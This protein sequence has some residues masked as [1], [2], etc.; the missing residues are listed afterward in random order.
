MKRN[1]L[2]FAGTIVLIPA[3][4]FSCERRSSTLVNPSGASEDPPV[5]VEAVGLEALYESL[6]AVLYRYVEPCS[7]KVNY[8]GFWAD[9][10][11][12]SICGRIARFDMG[13]LEIRTDSLAFL[14]NAYNA[15]FIRQLRAY[16]P[17][18]SVTPGDMVPWERMFDDT[19]TV[20]GHR[21]TL[22]QLEK[23]DSS[24]IKRFNEPRTHFVL[25]C[26]AKSC[27]PLLGKAYRGGTLY[28]AL[29]YQT[30]RFI[31]NGRFNPL[32]SSP[33]TVSQ[34][35]SWYA[36]EFSGMVRD[37]NPD[38]D[39]KL[40]TLENATVKDFIGSYLSDPLKLSRLASEGLSFK[41]YNWEINQL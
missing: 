39:R 7:G 33:P 18:D 16:M 37:P 13:A 8:N 35:F 28:Q 40:A 30:K 19:L 26:G 23:N 22:D 36:G 31:R 24:F 17:N 4:F 41:V 21:T 20:A 29:D 9:P 15:M 5:I 38:N 3:L 6:D 14:L 2:S 10:E 1:V 11:L 34:L 25:N 32:E 27:P 12:D